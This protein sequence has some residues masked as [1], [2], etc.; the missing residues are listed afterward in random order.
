MADVMPVEKGDFLTK[1]RVLVV[2]DEVLIRLWM[3][4]DLR[5]AGFT[6]V[7]ASNVDE[8]VAVLG[9]NTDI[10]ILLTDINMPGQLNGIDLARWV[11]QNAPHIRVAIASA[12]VEPEMRNEFD[13]IF[14][15]PVHMADVIAK[16]RQ[17]LPPK[18]QSGPRDR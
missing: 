4:D 6:V 17:L 7:E 15:K 18:E 16:L 5:R 1:P 2:E 9:A 11:R 12:N 3:A 10:D 14:R 13:A 8:A